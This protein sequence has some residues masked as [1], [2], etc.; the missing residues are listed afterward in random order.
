MPQN[1]YFSANQNAKR[2]HGGPTNGYTWMYSP[3]SHVGS[4]TMR[5]QVKKTKNAKKAPKPTIKYVDRPTPF[6]TTGGNI[7]QY[8]GSFVGMPGIGK[9]IGRFL[10][11][12]IG[13]IF[14]S[15]D[16]SVVGSKP[17]YNVLSGSVPQFSTTRATN[18][19]CHREYVGDITGTTAFTNVSFPI[20][21]G[22]DNTFPWLSTVASGYSQYRIHGM[23]FEFNPLITDFVTG[24]AP[25]VVIMST[26][27]DA[28]ENSY[29]SK[30]EMENAEY[31]V[32]V[33]PTNQLVH[34]VECDPAQTS[35]NIQYVR[36]GPITTGDLKTY[37]HGNFQ[38]ATQGNPAQLLGE[39]Y[40]SY[41]VEFFKPVLPS[42]QDFFEA[43]SLRY[44]RSGVT[45]LLPFGSATTATSGQ[46][47][48]TITSTGLTMTNLTPGAVYCAEIAWHGTVA[49]AFAA[50]T[51]SIAGGSGTFVNTP[52][53]EGDT[54]TNT[55]TTPAGLSATNAS[56]IVHFRPVGTI[57]LLGVGTTG[58]YPGGT[59]T[60]DI[61]VSILDPTL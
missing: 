61:Y 33:K 4:N 14:G 40:V 52:G 3:T 35:I 28:Q 24:G 54:A 57:M 26:N 51:F 38:F 6:T 11:A 42:S 5:K 21:P 37:D 10:G 7:G 18:I 43:R 17:G 44:F 55:T 23:I 15:G 31:A 16:Y 41:C 12:G 48:S 49:S 47:T 20:N 50:P 58:T 36:T 25:G 59:V 45:A 30:Q 22:M 46:L 8:A 39:L 9:G 1:Y 29:A 19:V 27:Y 53:F 32:S 13:S 2:L 60:V 34:M 56:Y